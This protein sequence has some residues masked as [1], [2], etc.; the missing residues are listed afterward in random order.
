[1]LRASDQPSADRAAYWRQVT[2]ATF[3]GLDIRL[4]RAPD[5]RDQIVIGEAGP[6]QVLDV[7]SGPGEARRGARHLRRHDPDRY[8]LYVQVE[9]SSVGEQ[10]DR[11]TTYRP[12][13]LGLVDLS[14]PLRCAYPERRA[15]MVS[16][17]K[18]LSPLRQDEAARLAGGLIKGG[19]G[20]PALVSGLVR[21]LPQHLDDDDGAAGARIGTA[22]LDLLHVGLAAE[23]DREQAVDPATRSRALL[24]RC[25]GY[26]EEHLGDRGLTP[27]AVA[28]EHHVSVRYL[29]RLF[30]PTGEGVATLVRRRRLD[31]CQ[32][33]LLDPRL[34]ERPVAAIGARWG[35]AD[36][37]HF[38]RAFKRVYGLPP[39]EF[40]EL[41]GG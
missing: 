16:Y 26:I 25:R 10:F 29:H 39:A 20:T 7:R 30:E 37:A 1:M 32:R 8:M 28:A 41:Y 23:L 9:G 35:F 4:D 36:A 33:D 13:D 2:E 34:V 24:H 38:T 22:V 11:C 17:P 18:A 31:R 27:A 12:G 40:R 14:A 15:V 19:R 5:E 21:E 3:G 6:L